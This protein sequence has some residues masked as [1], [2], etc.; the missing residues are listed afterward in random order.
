MRSY[1]I[2]R[3]RA[4]R[5]QIEIDF[6]LHGADG[7]KGPASRWAATARPGDVIGLYGPSI[8]HYRT[9]GK[10]AWKLMVGDETAL[11]A[12]GAL[13]ESRAPGERVVVYAEVAGAAEEQRWETAAQ[14][15]VHWVHRG[16]TPPGRSTLLP[17]AV[18][19]AEF[20]PDP[21]FAWV[22]GEASAVRSVRRHLV[23]ERGIDRRA[24][25]FTGYWR[26]HLTQDDDP[27]PED[28]TDEAEAVAELAEPAPHEEP[29]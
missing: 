27:T 22:A 17:D 9:P 2:R 24:V 6:A 19:V 29:R 20:P 1:T 10:H 8:S 13:L 25:A 4:D 11:P 21:V 16:D 28:A 5:Q 18:R 3:D 15:D 7:G 23:G 14:V 12:I 26:L